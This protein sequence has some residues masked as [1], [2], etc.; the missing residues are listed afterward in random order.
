MTFRQVGDTGGTAPAA[1]RERD[2]PTFV[3]YGGQK[4]KE[5]EEKRNKPAEVDGF[6]LVA[7][8]KV[9]GE[10]FDLPTLDTLVLA[11]PTRFKGNTIQQIG[12]ITRDADE[13]VA[14]LREANVHDFKDCLVPVLNNMFRK[15]RNVIQKEGFV[16]G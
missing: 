8:D 6:C 10:G 16:A 14:N 5:R 2:I 15:R 12:R 3:L 13:V 7:I 4:P 1:L 11:A 9:A